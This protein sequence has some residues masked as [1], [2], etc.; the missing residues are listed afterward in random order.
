MKRRDFV[1][2]VPLTALLPAGLS[3]LAGCE[4]ESGSATATKAT[5]Q[6]TFG[7]SQKQEMPDYAGKIGY[8]DMT[9]KDA[10]GNPQPGFPFLYQSDPGF[11]QRVQSLTFSLFLFPCSTAAL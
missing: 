5:G 10:D 11:E 8:S 6:P 2:A 1:K 7:G 3:A 4:A 9:S